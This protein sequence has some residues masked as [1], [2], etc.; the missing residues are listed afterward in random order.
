MPG[1]ASAVT[2][3]EDLKRLSPVAGVFEADG[4]E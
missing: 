4:F 2:L 3:F 1:C